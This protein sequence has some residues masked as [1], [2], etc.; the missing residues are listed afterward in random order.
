MRESTVPFVEK[1]VKYYKELIKNEIN[2]DRMQVLYD[3]KKELE[4]LL[5]KFWMEK[6]EKGE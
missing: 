1:L 5:L 3:N 4:K 2:L 6:I